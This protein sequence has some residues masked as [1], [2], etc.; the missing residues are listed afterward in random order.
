ML[1]VPICCERD[2][3][4][5]LRGQNNIKFGTPSLFVSITIYIESP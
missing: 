5:D 2:M 3:E 4:D 1:Y